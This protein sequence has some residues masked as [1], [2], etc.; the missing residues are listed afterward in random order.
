MSGDANLTERSLLIDCHGDTLLGIL[1]EPVQQAAVAGL[2]TASGGRGVLIVVGGPQYRVGSHRQFVLLARELARRGIAVLRFDYRGMGDSDGEY[3]GF[4]HLSAD[5]S[6]ALEAFR[7]ARPTLTDVVLWGLCDGASAAAFHAAEFPQSVAG[8]V[9]VNPWVRTE[10]GL[11]QAYVRSYYGRRLL[12]WS[13]WQ[14]MLRGEMHIVATLRGFFSDVQKARG[15]SGLKQPPKKPQEQPSARDLPD[16]VRLALA[17]FT[18]PV[19]LILSGQ[20]LTA[21]EFAAC[22]AGEEWRPILAR[23]NVQR[24]DYP[25]ADHTF[26]RRRW[27]DAMSTAC[28][29]WLRSW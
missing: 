29:D 16:R 5:I 9:M 17:T 19:L 1:H 3:R 28:A 7:R 12:Q 27:Q 8:L 22:A 23:Q 26:S 6:A 13:F 25:E 10:Q 11:A 14:K 20:D 21:Q 24:V 4:E 18:G 2:S 15:A